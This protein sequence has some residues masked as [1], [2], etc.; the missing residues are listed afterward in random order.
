MNSFNTSSDIFLIRVVKKNRDRIIQA[1]FFAK[2]G[3]IIKRRSTNHFAP[4][5]QHTSNDDH[6]IDTFD[7]QGFSCS[8]FICIFMT[9]LNKLVFN[10]GK[11]GCQMG[12]KIL[13]T[14]PRVTQRAN[15]IVSSKR[16]PLKVCLLLFS[17]SIADSM[18]K[19]HFKQS[20]D[21]CSPVKPI[22][23]YKFTKV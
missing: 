6:K 4:N 7:P 3:Q 22:N 17:Y 13:T 1:R 15:K 20:Y 19:C 9:S 5:W 12:F 18:F 2:Q 16:E 14:N 11:M 8:F 10:K 21:C 23:M